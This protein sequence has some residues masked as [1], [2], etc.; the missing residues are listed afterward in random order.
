M[1][2]IS[3]QA[4]TIFEIGEIAISTSM[5]GSAITTLI[6]ILIGLLTVRKA[7]IIPTKAQIIF[8]GIINAFMDLLVSA[9]GSKKIARK[10]APFYITI[11]VF[12]LIAN[13]FAIIPIINSIVTEDGLV[14]TTPTANFSQP[15]A[16]TIMVLGIAHF[17]ALAKSPLKH[18]D[19]FI[20]ISPF[21]KIK[22][23]SDFGKAIGTF[24]MGISDL[25]A[26]VAKLVSLSA[27]LF[28]NVFAGEV[29]VIV[30]AGITAY[31]QYIIPLPFIVLSIFSGLVQAYVFAILSIQFMA[32]TI[33]SVED[34]PTKDIET[35]PKL[36]TENL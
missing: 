6:I 21:F 16:L 24:L 18:I 15:I 36:Q 22:K 30:I 31:T 1:Q 19:N 20:K 2:E 23:P 9:Y 8:E 35:A 33:K 34:E 27:R 17:L 13:Q 29:M 7:R 11:F 25:I 14:F 4:N 28:G 26:E 12:L 5:L 3:L 32:G 10:W